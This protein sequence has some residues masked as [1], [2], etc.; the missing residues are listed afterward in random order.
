[1]G[2]VFSG[3]VLALLSVDVFGKLAQPQE[4]VDATRELGFDADLVP[5]IGLLLLVG[6][7]LYAIP[8]TAFLGA[9]WTT[10]YLGGAVCANLRAEEP[11]ATQVLAPVY[12]AVLMWGGLFLRN[13]RLRDV[14]AGAR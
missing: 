4:V 12:V 14:V 2:R 8:R 9:L 5:V 6:V 13:S 7:V 1:M 3:L 11:I 10:A